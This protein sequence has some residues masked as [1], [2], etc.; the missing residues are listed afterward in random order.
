MTT[1]EQLWREFWYNAQLAD[2]HGREVAYFRATF[3]EDERLRSLAYTAQR[4]AD[5]ERRM[6]G[7]AYRTPD[8]CEVYWCADGLNSPTDDRFAFTVYIDRFM[9]A[10]WAAQD[11]RFSFDVESA[12]GRNQ[13]ATVCAS[14]DDAD[15]DADVAAALG[16]LKRGWIGQD[17]PPPPSFPNL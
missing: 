6:T 16:A 1:E 3:T 14:R 10:E 11:P 12:K 7:R 4:V 13:L 2:V 8:M 15:T 17:F 5:D 9:S